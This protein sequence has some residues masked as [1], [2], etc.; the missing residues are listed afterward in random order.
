MMIDLSL[1]ELYFI[2][3][4]LSLLTARRYRPAKFPTQKLLSW[5]NERA[6]GHQR[7]SRLH[8]GGTSRNIRDLANHGCAAYA[9]DRRTVG[10]IESRVHHIL[11]GNLLRFG[12][13]EYY[14]C[15]LARDLIPL[16]RS[17]RL[18]ARLAL[19]PGR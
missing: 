13:L 3:N 14:L 12:E 18:N 4:C 10:H 19:S 5:R 7:F 1:N 17:A 9:I 2:R 11:T 8:P 6:V 15:N 16:L